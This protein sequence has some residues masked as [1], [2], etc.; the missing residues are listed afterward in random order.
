[1]KFHVHI[2][3]RI[4]I[5]Y[6]NSINLFLFIGLWSQIN[7]PCHGLGHTVVYEAAYASKRYSFFK[8]PGWAQ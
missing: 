8:N 7:V 5:Q 1:M 3:S 2:D 4:Q 6:E